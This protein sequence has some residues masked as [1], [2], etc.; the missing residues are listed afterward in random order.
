[1]TA[2][3]RSFRQ[4]LNAASQAVTGGDY[5]LLRQSAHS[6]KGTLLQCG[7]S[8]LAEV[9]EAIDRHAEDALAGDYAGVLAGLR[10]ALADITAPEERRES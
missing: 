10:E 1:M 5:Q 8:S 7:L 3:G 6:L 9:A 2:A 4:H